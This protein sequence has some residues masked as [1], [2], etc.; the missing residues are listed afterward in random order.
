MVVRL[1][2]IH[3]R[4]HHE[5]E[6]LERDDQRMEQDPAG[7]G[8]DV[9]QPQRDAG[10]RPDTDRTHQR[11]S[12]GG[13]VQQRR[14]A[15]RDF[16]PGQGLGDRRAQRSGNAT[17]NG[18]RTRGN[19]LRDF[20]LR[21]RGGAPVRERTIAIL[22]ERLAFLRQNFPGEYKK[23][24]ARIVDERLKN[25]QSEIIDLIYPVL[26]N[27][28]KKYIDHQFQMLKEAIE[29]RLNATR[30][31]LNFWKRLRN[32]FAGIKESDLILAAAAPP[33]TVMDV[34]LIEKDSGLL[35]GQATRSATIDGESLAGMLTAIK[36]F[37]QDAFQ[38]GAEELDLIQYQQSKILMQNYRSYYV[39]AV[40]QGSFSA[41]ERQQLTSRLE[42]FI[43]QEFVEVHNRKQ[44]PGFYDHISEE[45][46]HWFIASEIRLIEKPD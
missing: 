24:V 25:S 13:E 35:L 32:R 6:C 20:A 41:F 27:L 34:F 29:S 8:R 39:A 16:R 33:L 15:G 17:G 9:A 31:Q 1:A 40:V 2:D 19:G 14:G 30:E 43:L 37:V 28:I 45:L 46:H 21:E 23:V 4:Q 26:G 3:Q 5:D 10:D 44:E 12:N 18:A 42:N 22:E 36:A 11:G 38:R 7:A